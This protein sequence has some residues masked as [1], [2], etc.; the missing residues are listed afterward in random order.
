MPIFLLIF[1]VLLIAVGCLFIAFRSDWR[2]MVTA[3]ALFYFVQFIFVLYT[4]SALMALA[5]LALGW[6]AT[7]IIA[8]TFINAK[9]RTS[10][11]GTTTGVSFKVISSFFFVLSGFA[12]SFTTSYWI[13]QLSF[14]QLSAGIILMLSG[15]LFLNFYHTPWQVV[16]SIMIFLSG[17]EIIEYGL[18]NSLLLLLLIGLVKVS[19]ALALFF[20]VRRES[21]RM[22]T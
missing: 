17:F 5:D 9:I 4:S 3:L 20:I 18:E 19:L 10:E 13:T 11:A 15:V 14:L 7:G 16:L 1:L 12:L 8:F 6:G 21:R 22:G 2:S